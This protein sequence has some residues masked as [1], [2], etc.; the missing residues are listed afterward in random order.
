MAIDIETFA[1]HDGQEVGEIRLDNGAGATASILTWGATVRDLK[2]PARDGVRRVVLGYE[3][4]EGYRE[5]PCYLGVTAGRVA[6]RTGGGGFVLDGKRH[7]LPPNEAGRTHLHGGPVGFSRRNWKILEGGS[8]FVRLG[9]VSEDGDQG[10]PGRAEVAVEYRLTA[11]PAALRITAT[12]NVDRPTYVN[13]AHH[14]YFTLSGDVRAHLLKMRAPF[15]TP[16]DDDKIPTGEISSVKGTPFDFTTTRSIGAAGVAYDHNFVLGPDDGEPAAVLTAPDG[17]LMM[18]LLTTEPAVQLYDGHM[19]PTVA[20][21]LGGV[22]HVPWAGVC[23]ESQR[24]PDAPNKPHFPSALVE[25]GRPYR[26]IT[27]YRFSVPA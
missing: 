10:W 15:T 24:F 4:F 5:N 3:T 11:S 18:E 9:L 22:R 23:L 20:P 7:V 27:E 8:D 1:I 13:L 17:G 16:V 6:N 21:T 12:A 2:V 25:P 14:S 26:Q 19:L